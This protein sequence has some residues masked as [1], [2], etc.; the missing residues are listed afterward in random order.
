M[1]LL[2]AAMSLELVPVR[3]VCS[4]T[5][6]SPAVQLVTTAWDKART[7]CLAPG[8]LLASSVARAA[9]G[10]L[11]N[12]ASL[13]GTHC[14]SLQ[15]G[16]GWKQEENQPLSKCPVEEFDLFLLPLKFFTR[17]SVAIPVLVAATQDWCPLSQSG[18]EW[19]VM[20]CL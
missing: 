16:W 3:I 10:R 14:Q 2:P 9:L 18:R 5:F 12:A 13:G 6:C 17:P 11:T 19:A 1:D 7:D 8:S 15:L 4:V 20:R